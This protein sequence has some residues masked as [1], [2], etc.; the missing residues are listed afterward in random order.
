M[1][2]GRGEGGQGVSHCSVMVGEGGWD[3]AGAEATEGGGGGHQCHNLRRNWW[4]TLTFL[5][6][7]IPEV[8]GHEGSSEATDEET[9]RQKDLKMDIC[10]SFACVYTTPYSTPF[11]SKIRF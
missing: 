7:D 10:T 2:W 8:T 5:E 4:H 6:L 1:R 3:R 11:L 9:V